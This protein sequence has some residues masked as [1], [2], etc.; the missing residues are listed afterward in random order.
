M[1]RLL[2]FITITSLTGFSFGQC[3]VT[4]GNDMDLG[5]Q[6]SHSPDY[7]LGSAITIT[8]SFSL[9]EMGMIAVNAGD[10][11]KVAVYDD[12]GGNPGNL[13]TEGS[14][15]TV[16]GVNVIDVPDV[17]LPAGTYYYMA[18]FETNASISYTGGTGATVY[19][20]SHVYS[21][22]LPISFGTA[23]VYNDQEFS[24]YFEG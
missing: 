16:V 8:G 18:V 1:K 22:T 10:N 2:L 4:A 24:Y 7:L 20:I 15:T 6:S 23:T 17:V 19:Y 5:N 13:L 12:A 3:N 9:T 14:G 11:F 21:N